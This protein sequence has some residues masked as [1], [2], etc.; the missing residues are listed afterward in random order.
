MNYT[1]LQNSLVKVK[2][3][4]KPV[5]DV[6]KTS[7]GLV[8]YMLKTCPSFI[9]ERNRQTLIFCVQID[10]LSKHYFEHK[11]SDIKIVK[12]NNSRNLGS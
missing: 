3:F 5:N 7:L 4:E 2:A 12:V 9:E 10:I 6:L 11:T 1:E 8:L